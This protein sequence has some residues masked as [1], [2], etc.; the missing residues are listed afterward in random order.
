MG[1]LRSG[2]IAAFAKTDKYRDRSLGWR[3][4]AQVKALDGQGLRVVIEAAAVVQQRHEKRAENRKAAEEQIRRLRTDEARKQTRAQTAQDAWAEW[5]DQWSVA[6][7]SLAFTDDIAVETAADHLD[8][9]DEIRGLSLV[10]LLVDDDPYFNLL[11]EPLQVQ[12]A[13]N[14]LIK[15]SISLN[16]IVVDFRQI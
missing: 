9:I 1:Q 16:D 13:A 11:F 12:H 6:L 14:G 3:E 2:K 7:K 10:G 4:R 15:S 5:L 8:V